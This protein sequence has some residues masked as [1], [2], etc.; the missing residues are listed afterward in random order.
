MFAGIMGNVVGSLYEGTQW[1]FKDLPLIQKKPF[2][3]YKVL[4][5]F[6]ENNLIREDYFWNQDT[7]CTLAL[8]S[9]YINN[10]E[11]VKTM[12]YFCKKYKNKN[13]VF[14]KRFNHWIEY[15]A[16][17]QSSSNAAIVRIGYIPFLTISFQ[18]KISLAFKV[19]TISHDHQ[20]SFKSIVDFL[21][22]SEQLKD[23]KKEDNF[24]KKCIK[25][26][27]IKEKFTKTFN[28]LHEESIIE[29]N[30]L[31]TLYQAC[32]ILLESNNMDEVLRNSFYIGGDS[33][34]LACLACN[35][36]SM[37]YT[38]PKELLNFSMNTLKEYDELYLLA[39]NFQHNYWK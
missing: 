27:L 22:L 8:Y 19:T 17:Y 24:E 39:K 33:D 28:E 11:P 13:I 6:K 25:E 1:Q 21:L 16:P 36:A 23:D 35:L 10:T 30:A 12:V 9:S 31:Q 26:Y 5:L 29:Y 18:E 32:V 37:I 20:D 38:C 3:K 2:D 7:L 4:P 34:T 15:P 14:S